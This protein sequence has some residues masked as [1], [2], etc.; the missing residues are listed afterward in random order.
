MRASGFGA[1]RIS[2]GSRRWWSGTPRNGAAARH[3]LHE[4]VAL[5]EGGK[6]SETLRSEHRNGAEPGGHRPRVDRRIGLDSTSAVGANLGKR[7]SKGD[8]GDP[9]SAL[10]WRDEE[11]GDSPIRNRGG[12][13]CK[14][15]V[16]PASVDSRELRSRTELTP[17]DG[18]TV[19]VDQHAVGAIA[20]DKRS[21]IQP[22]SVST[23]LV[24]FHPSR[25]RAVIEH[26]PTTG[27]HA[28][29]S[30]EELLKVCPGRG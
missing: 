10:R 30:S 25:T 3:S 16:L 27:R 2:T 1:G 4:H 14:R 29:T 18:P 20:F 9:L 11:A 21:V 7:G 23:V 22:V 8:L 24:G 15:P 17:S 26:A 19:M 13:Q 5:A 12:G 28:A 6:L